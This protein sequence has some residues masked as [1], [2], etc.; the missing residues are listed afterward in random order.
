MLTRIKCNNKEYQNIL[1]P[2]YNIEKIHPAHALSLIELT[3]QNLWEDSRY[4]KHT[5]T[6][7]H[8]IISEALGNE[9]SPACWC[10]I[11]N[12]RD[13]VLW[14]KNIFLAGRQRAIRY[15]H[16]N[17][18]E[19]IGGIPKREYGFRNIL[20]P[21]RVTVHRDKK[22]E[23]MLWRQTFPQLKLPPTLAGENQ[24]FFYI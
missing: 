13:L 20:E 15:G 16:L 8:F 22:G 1:P 7:I 21:G 12:H 9:V 11:F 14:F 5:L 6:H 23:Q 17:G 2:E 18:N 19:V 10:L 24:T 4:V 3:T